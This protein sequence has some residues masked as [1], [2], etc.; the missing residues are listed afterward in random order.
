MSS[1]ES[2]YSDVFSYLRFLLAVERRLSQKRYKTVQHVR[3]IAAKS[4]EY[5]IDIWNWRL[6]R[7]E[8]QVQLAK[9]R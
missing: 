4:A 2:N 1:V 5:P 3:Q 7:I 6:M 8:L 9:L